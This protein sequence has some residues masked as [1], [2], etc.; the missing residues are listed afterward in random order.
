MTLAAGVLQFL[1]KVPEDL[2]VGLRDRWK[3]RRGLAW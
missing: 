1:D 3:E 2:R